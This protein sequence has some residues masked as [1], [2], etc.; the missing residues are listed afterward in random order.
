MA[1]NMPKPDEL[2]S[3]SISNGADGQ[4]SSLVAQVMALVDTFRTNG[5]TKS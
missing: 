5:V 3:V 1:A 4:V 2:R